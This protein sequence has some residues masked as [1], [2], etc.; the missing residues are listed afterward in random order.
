MEKKLL[1]VSLILLILFGLSAFADE[2]DAILIPVE[3]TVK[4]AL[5]K[6]HA[7]LYPGISQEII[8]KGDI[9]RDALSHGRL[10]NYDDES[11]D[12]YLSGGT[13]GDEWGIWF[14]SPQADCSLYAVEFM[15]SSA[16]GGGTIN[17]DV[18]EAGSVS[19]A[20]I[21]N[22]DSIAVTDIFSTGNFFQVKKMVLVK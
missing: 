21:P 2:D 17:L 10:S 8:L 20:T 14:Q 11:V 18:M 15:F 5:T 16:M 6:K 1:I 13:A 3:K 12:Y 4:P 19:P 9:N 7:Y 22:S